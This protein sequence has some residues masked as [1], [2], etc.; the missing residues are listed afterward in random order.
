MRLQATT[1]VLSIIAFPRFG[2]W[3]DQLGVYEGQSEPCISSRCSD[4]TLSFLLPIFEELTA[5]E[6]TMTSFRITVAALAIG[7]FGRDVPGNVRSFYDRIKDGKCNGGTVLQDGFY[8]SDY[9]PQ[10]KLQTREAA[11]VCTGIRPLTRPS[12]RILLR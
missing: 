12:F 10:C 7:A 4:N 6:M 2:S 8:S 5:H 3:R 11:K 1:L 9:G